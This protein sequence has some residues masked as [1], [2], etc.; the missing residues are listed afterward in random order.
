[1]REISH[2]RTGALAQDV[3]LNIAHEGLDSICIKH[4]NHIVGVLLVMAVKI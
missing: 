2:P 4:P 1:M 3:L